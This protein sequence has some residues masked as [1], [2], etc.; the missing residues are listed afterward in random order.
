MFVIPPNKINAKPEDISLMSYN[1]LLPNSEQGWWVYKYYHPDIPNE[2]RTWEARKRLLKRQ[3]SLEIDL[4][5]FQ[6]C[7]LNTYEGD[8]DFMTSTHTL[9]C[10]K[11]AR[12]AMVTAWKSERFELIAEYHLNRT[13]VTV[14]RERTGLILCIVNCHLSAGRHPKE[15][16]QQVSKAMQQVEKLKNR[17]DLDLIVFSGDFNSSSEGTAVL[18]FLEDGVVEP[19]FREAYYPQVEITSKIKEHQLGRFEEVYRHITDATTMWV[20]NSGAS[21]LHQRKRTPLKSFLDGLE[22]LFDSYSTNGENLNLGEVEQ[23]ILDI[24]GDLR[25]S[26]YLTA[27][28]LM[29]NDHL[30]KSHFIELYLAEVNAGKHWAVFN[31]LLRQGIELP[32]PRPYVARYA[33]DQIWLRSNRYE[34]TGVVPPIAP[35]AK[36]KI[37]S[38]DFPPNTW[39]PSDHF[40]LM[41]R[42]SP[43]LW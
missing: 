38:G 37:E 7:S 36:E 12:I 42:F 3:I 34:C 14:L 24:N 41:V 32:R 40:P 33:L 27:L 29:E 18:R 13:L 39:H 10:H 9:L 43:K 1:I 21:M 35:N 6:E 2:D 16:F 17:F 20:R 30:S 19:R 23:W 31:D 28:E 22:R 26:E 15:R 11:R 4:F 25:G 8:L 5:T